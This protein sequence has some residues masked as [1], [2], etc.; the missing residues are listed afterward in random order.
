[1]ATPSASSYNADAIDLADLP[2]QQGFHQVT[3]FGAGH[4]FGADTDVI[5]CETVVP[6]LMSY[7]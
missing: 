7:L 6:D 3:Q 4:V 2:G 1:M 5:D